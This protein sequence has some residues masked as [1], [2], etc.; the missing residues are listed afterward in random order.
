MHVTGP[1]FDLANCALQDRLGAQ[2]P[3]TISALCTGGG[4]ISLGIILK[5][6]PPLATLWLAVV[7]TSLGIGKE[8]GICL[9]RLLITRPFLRGLQLIRL[10]GRQR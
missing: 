1:L 3:L 5:A 8:F 4:Y 10:K 9:Y 7:Y 6:Q 2:I